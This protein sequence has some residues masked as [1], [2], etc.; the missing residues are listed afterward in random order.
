MTEKSYMTE[1]TIIQMSEYQWTLKA[2]HL[3]CA[4]AHS[5]RA[6]V[7]LLRLDYVRHPGYLG[8]EFGYT[9]PT[10]QETNLFAACKTIAE[11]YGILLRFESIQCATTVGA[12]VTAA[13]K[14]FAD[15][16]VAPLSAQS[17]P[18]WRE[19]QIW[20]LTRQL[21]AVDCQ[22][23][24]LDKLFEAISYYPKMSVLHNLSPIRKV[25]AKH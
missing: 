15:C 22:F 4:M 5:H 19:F 18:L 10:V 1:T 16:L 13:D 8:S 25:A 6:N 11:Q 21:S 3:A 9:A 24:T 2:V 14:F 12:L 20:N 7:I 23:F 17:I